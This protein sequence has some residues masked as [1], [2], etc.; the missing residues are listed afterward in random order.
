MSA[1]GPLRSAISPP[2]SSTTCGGATSGLWDSN[3][4]VASPPLLL[5]LGYSDAASNVFGHHAPQRRPGLQQGL[6]FFNFSFFWSPACMSVCVGPPGY[7]ID[8]IH[9]CEYKF[10]YFCERSIDYFLGLLLFIFVRI[11]FF[12]TLSLSS[13]VNKLELISEDIVVL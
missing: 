11:F 13:S 10:V 12:F 7:C 6:V 2:V 4:A 5:W 8:K 3:S 9:L 1:V